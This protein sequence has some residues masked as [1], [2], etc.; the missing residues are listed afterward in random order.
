[1]IFGGLITFVIYRPKGI[2]D[3]QIGMY[4]FVCVSLFLMSG[5]W[6]CIACNHQT[7]D[8]TD[9]LSYL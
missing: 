9:N 8:E 5:V 2:T 3:F 4:F 7:E 1:M 6:G